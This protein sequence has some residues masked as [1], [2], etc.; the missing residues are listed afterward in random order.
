MSTPRTPRV[1]AV[2]WDLGGV[3]IGWDP[4][5]L[6]RRLLRSDEEVEAYLAE[7]DFAGWNRLQDA[8]RPMA[9]GVAELSARFP[10]R[11]EL[12][13]AYPARYA[14][15]LLGPVPGS[16]ELLDELRRRGQVRLLALTNWSADTFHH[17]RDGYPF[18]TWF[19]AVV[20]S[21]E[22]RL[23]KPDPR[24]FRRVLDRHGLESATTVYVDDSAANVAAAGA[25]GLIALLF[26][27]AEK[28]RSELAALGLVAA[29]AP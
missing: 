20:V 5:V 15:T 22:E 28:L 18:L 21:G 4:R 24:L 14:E 12:V 7:V 8:G 3:L 25:L 10:H 2:V 6:Y 27:G 11:R 17:A 26:T 16:V 29:A 13:A 1:D 23:A 19:E 9:E